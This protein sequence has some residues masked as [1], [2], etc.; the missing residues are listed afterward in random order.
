M[1]D[2]DVA[3]FAARM[4]ARRGAMA[5]LHAGLRA[6]QLETDG[7]PVRSGDWAR[8]AAALKTLAP[9]R[10]ARRRQG[11][12]VALSAYRERRGDAASPAPGAAIPT[13]SRSLR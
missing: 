5:A 7:D 1:I 8:V 2:K 12:L 6:V 4:L 11:E 3:W 10:E 9:Q 13:R